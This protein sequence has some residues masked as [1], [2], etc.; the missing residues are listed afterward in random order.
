MQSELANVTG[1]TGINVQC[2]NFYDIDSQAMSLTG[3]DQQ[4]QQLSCGKFKGISKT[5]SLGSELGLHFEILN[6]I[7]DQSGGVPRDRFLVVFLMN[8]RG[9]CKIK[10]QDFT[11][12]DVFFA[13]P[14]TYIK[15]ISGPGVNS[16]VINLNKQFFETILSQNYPDLNLGLDIPKYGILESSPAFASL[17]RQSSNQTIQLIDACQ[18]S[19][20]NDQ[21][22]KNIRCS[23]VE[24]IAEHLYLT[25]HQASKNKPPDRT[26]RFQIVKMA[27]EYINQQQERYISISDLC[28]QTGVSRR[29]LEY[30]FRDCIGQSPNAYLRSIKLNGIRRSLLA[31]ENACKSIGDMAA[32]WGVW[33]L[34][35]FAQNYKKQFHELPSE[36]RIKTQSLLSSPIESRGFMS[37]LDRYSNNAFTPGTEKP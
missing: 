6:Q 4:Y 17:L 21:T 26:R 25:F 15:G 10:G 20:I 14:G 11:A 12:N 19:L 35:R 9:C 31:P 5:V 28:H 37:D 23:L 36:T 27:C 29:T 1:D 18:G 33:H 22:L 16:A 7:L 3:Y 2:Q 32:E 34:S 13:A 8:R 24:G 30:S